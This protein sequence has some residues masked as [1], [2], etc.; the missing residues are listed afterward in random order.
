[1]FCFLF[2]CLF[3]GE[4]YSQF[5][6]FLADQFLATAL[7][8]KPHIRELVAGTIQ[9]WDAEEISEKLE[10]TIGTDLQFIRLNGTIVGGF[11]GLAIH[12]LFEFLLK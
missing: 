3:A 6:P 7:A 12:A 11:I 10:S 4:T 1:M 8:S 2:C 5:N 9:K